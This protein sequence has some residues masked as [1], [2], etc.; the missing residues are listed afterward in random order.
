MPFN[1]NP[2][3]IDYGGHARLIMDGVGTKE[4]DEGRFFLVSNIEADNIFQLGEHFIHSL[5]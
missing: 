4:V 1:R 5:L 3:A 2:R